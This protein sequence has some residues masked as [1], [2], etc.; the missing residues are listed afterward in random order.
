[1][2]RHVHIDGMEKDRFDELEPA[3][4]L[5]RGTQG[6][7]CGCVRLLPTTGP[8]MLRDTFPELLHG[9]PMPTNASVWET[10]RF[11]LDAPASSP[12]GAG[13]TALF[14]YELFSGVVEYG[15]ANNLTQI[16]TVTDARLERILRHAN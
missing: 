15:L 6:Q 5:L 8:T 16:I 10:S 3:Y 1:M 4:L 11:A 7:V 13:G 12:V 9:A 14:S 2:P